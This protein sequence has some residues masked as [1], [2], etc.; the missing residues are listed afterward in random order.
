[1]K[2]ELNGNKIECT[3]EEYMQLQGKTN[4]QKA[5]PAQV[6]PVRQRRH[7]AYTPNED[8][9]IKEAYTTPGNFVKYKI[10]K[11]VISRLVRLLKRTRESISNRAYNLN[12]TR[13]VN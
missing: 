5:A 7:Y 8:A 11:K 4:T 3:V 9:V 1:M 12:L 2:V 13:H 6:A 10:K